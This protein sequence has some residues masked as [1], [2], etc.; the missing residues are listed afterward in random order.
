MALLL[1]SALPAGADVIYSNLQDLSIPTNFDGIYLDV[2]SGS[3][4]TSGTI[5]WDLNLFYGGIGVV[6]STSFQPVREVDAGNGTLSNLAW[7]ATV[8]ASSTFD[9]GGGGGGSTDHLGTNYTAGQEGYLGF[10]LSSGNYGW[11][12]VVLDGSGSAFVNDWA[13]DNTGGTGAIA[14]GNVLQSGSTVTVDSSSGSFTLGSQLSGSNS[15]VKNGSGTTTLSA[16][17][18][19][20]GTTTVSSGMLLVNGDNSAATGALSVESGA[21]LGGSGTIGGITTIQSGGILAAGNSPGV[22]TFAD[23]LTLDAGSSLMMEIA[24]TARGTEYDGIDVAGLLTYGGTLTL[25]SDT[26][27]AHGIYDLFGVVTETGDF[28]SMILSGAAYSNEAFAQ[29]GDIWTVTVG[30]DTY[31]FSQ[32]TGDLTVVP[33]PG[34]YALLAGLTGLVHV[35]L[36]R[37][38]R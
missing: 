12:R 33:E 3:N 21:T 27:I 26:L 31:N 16:D 23:A 8:N 14:T 34:T 13:Y 25:T 28:A 20:T 32:L 2:E 11:M 29:F 1:A 36:R 6:N 4:D 37:R 15:L 17:N 24:G 7:G 30:Y 19:N 38:R 22:L 9:T 5:A 18:T 35:I 10:Q